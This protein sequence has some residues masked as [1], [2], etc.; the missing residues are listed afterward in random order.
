MRDARFAALAFSLAFGCTVD[1]PVDPQ[2]VAE[3]EPAAEANA[4]NQAQPNQAQQNQAQNQ[5]A[6]EPMELEPGVTD[7]RDLNAALQQLGRLMTKVRAAVDE[8]G[9]NAE[10]DDCA[11][12]RVIFAASNQA[13]D[14][15]VAE[16]PLPG[17]RTPP[18]WRIADEPTFARLC[19]QLPADVQRCLRLDVR[20]NDRETCGPLLRD[21]PED[22]KALTVQLAD[23]VRE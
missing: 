20:S 3:A 7:V 19:H 11:K 23:S 21:L 1:Q 15:A 4:P 22:Q 12:A 13:L 16:E 14:A 9:A 10:G 8:A 18:K 5:A 17:G 2:P 6:R